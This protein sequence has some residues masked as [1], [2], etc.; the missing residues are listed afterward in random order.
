[1]DNSAGTIND[2]Y[3]SITDR[4]AKN[5]TDNADDNTDSNSDNKYINAAVKENKGR[6][7]EHSDMVLGCIKI[8]SHIKRNDDH[9]DKE[10]AVNVTDDSP[11]DAIKDSFSAGNNLCKYKNNFTNDKNY[12]DQDE[13]KSCDGRKGRIGSGSNKYNNDNFVN[14]D[15]NS[16]Y[17]SASDF[18]SKN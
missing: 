18:L 6:G 14:D 2:A 9:N 17:N 5:N 15:D 1:L 10:G 12:N 11:E 16:K 7:P 4:Y 8:P 3:H 13:C